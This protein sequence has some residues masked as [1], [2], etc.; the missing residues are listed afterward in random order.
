MNKDYEAE[1]KQIRGYVGKNEIKPPLFQEFER[2]TIP[3]REP[4]KKPP[5]APTPLVSALPAPAFSAPAPP[6]PALAG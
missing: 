4:V 2:K 6:A 3:T 1:R 5:F